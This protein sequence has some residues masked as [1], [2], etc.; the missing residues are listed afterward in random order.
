LLLGAGM[1]M[2]SRAVGPLGMIIR[3]TQAGS[4]AHNGGRVALP[5]LHRL[6]VISAPFMVK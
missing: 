1:R 6:R 2:E 5:D 4:K 3:K